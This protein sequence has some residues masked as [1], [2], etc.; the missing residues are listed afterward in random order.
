[1]YISFMHTR[2]LTSALFENLYIKVAEQY[3]WTWETEKKNKY[4]GVFT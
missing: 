4:G 1:M 2:P 3:K